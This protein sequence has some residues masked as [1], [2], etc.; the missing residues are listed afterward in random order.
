MKTKRIF[1]LNLQ[2]FA[3]PTDPTGGAGDPP[4]A[5]GGTPPSFDDLLKDPAVQS[6]FDKRVAKALA[7]GKTNWEKEKNMT[8][9]QLAQQKI[10]EREADIQKREG[11]ITKRELRLKALEILGEKKL[12]A[13]LANRL[14]YSDEASM[15]VS[16]KEVEEDFRAALEEGVNERLKGN[17]PPAGKPAGAADFDKQIADAKASGNMSLVASLIRQKAESES[18]SK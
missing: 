13:R 5:S 14:D 18:K 8:A 9:E 11:E 15:K 1:P 3:A 10:Q 16:L 4:P 7:T 2:Y 12:P 17:P 6:E